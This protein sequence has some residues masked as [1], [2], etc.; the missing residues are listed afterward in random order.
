M[1]RGGDAHPVQ[2]RDRQAAV[3]V[4]HLIL[5]VVVAIGCGA[6]ASFAGREVSSAAAPDREQAE[7]IL[8]QAGRLA[9]S[10][11]LD[12][13]CKLGYIDPMCRRH[14]AMFGGKAAVPKQPPMDLVTRG[15]LEQSP[16]SPDGNSYVLVLRGKDGLGCS[17]EHHFAV[18]Y[19]ENGDLKAKDP[20]YWTGIHGEQTD[21][22]APTTVAQPVD[23]GC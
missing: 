4:G 13:L 16:V 7:D 2:G 8:T 21:V 10:G 23:R 22:T 12:A 11:D 3:G 19:D 6:G 9:R 1:R 14:F 15:Y 17:F 5:V 20:V 18:F